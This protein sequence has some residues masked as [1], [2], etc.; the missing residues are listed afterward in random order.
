MIKKEI[1]EVFIT[2]DGKEFPS[3]NEAQAH[4]YSIYEHCYD[5]ILEFN[6]TY[7]TRV[8]ACSESEAIKKANDEWEPQNLD[9]EKTKHHVYSLY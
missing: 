5:I 1:K 8:M 6:A 9:L 2:S 4:E 7:H 3:I